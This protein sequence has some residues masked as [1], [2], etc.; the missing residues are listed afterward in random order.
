MF[1]TSLA[2]DM[3][4]YNRVKTVVKNCLLELGI[5]TQEDDLSKLLNF[6]CL[7]NIKIRHE[8]NKRKQAGEK[9][10]YINTSLAEDYHRSEKTIEA[11]IARRR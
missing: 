6:N 11:I 5:E 1:D 10:D 9:I 8:C 2:T 7:R 4:I 3:A